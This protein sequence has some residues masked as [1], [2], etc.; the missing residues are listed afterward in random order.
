M[1]TIENFLQEL[2]DKN[3]SSLDLAYYYSA[4]MD[5]EEYNEAIQRGIYENEIIYYSN[6]IKYLSENDPSLTESMNIASD[7]GFE[8]GNINSELLATLL[9][10]QE[11]HDEFSSYYSEIKTYFEENL[12]TELN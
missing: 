1:E 3:Y 8:T 7:F 11:L 9:Y 12:Q 2:N 10:Q 4:G 5:F 6:A